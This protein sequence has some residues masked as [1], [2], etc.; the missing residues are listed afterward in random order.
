MLLMRQSPRLHAT[1]SETKRVYTN[2]KVKRHTLRCKTQHAAFCSLTHVMDFVSPHL[3]LVANT[4]PARKLSQ[5]L[6]ALVE[7]MG[8]LSFVPLAIQV[9]RASL[10]SRS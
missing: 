2:A 8:L 7:D 9:G 5:A 3:H 1:Y 4:N 6:C 10:V